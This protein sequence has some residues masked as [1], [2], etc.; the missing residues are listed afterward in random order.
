LSY[1][2]TH[3]GL[4]TLGYPRTEQIRDGGNLVQYFQNAELI[5]DPTHHSVYPAPLGTTMLR[6]LAGRPAFLTIGARVAKP[7]SRLYRQL[8][9]EGVLGL[10]VENLTFHQ[11]TPVQVFQYGEMA[12]LHGTPWLVPLGDAALQFRGWLPARGA[13]DTYPPTMAPQ[14]LPPAPVFRHL[15]VRTLKLHRIYDRPE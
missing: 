5:Y 13:G 11:G 4:Q 10:P 14:L 7:F 1:F 6:A 9:G 12:L 2:A 15:H 8:G 3:G